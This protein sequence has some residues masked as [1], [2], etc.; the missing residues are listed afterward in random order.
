VAHPEPHLSYTLIETCAGSAA[1]TWHLLGSTR[2]IVPYQGSKWR[3]RRELAMLIAKLGFT[4]KPSHCHLADIGPWGVVHEVLFDEAK[5]AK[6]IAYLE[7]LAEAKDQ[8]ALYQGMLR[9]P[10]PSVQAE[11]VLYVAEFLYLQRLAFSGKAVGAKEGKWTSPG[12]NKTSAYGKAATEVFGEIKPQ[13]PS[14]IRVLGALSPTGTCT[15]TQS[16]TLPEVEGPT[17]A[18]IDPPYLGT[19]KYPD[20]HMGRD[21]VVYLAL[22]LQARGATVLVSEAEPIPELVAQ[23]WPTLQLGVKKGA[24]PFQTTKDTPR[25]EWVTYRR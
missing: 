9:R 16:E 17:L 22:R 12:F 11:P 20:G 3:Y 13:V 10:R 15:S 1:L 2:A 14:M 25:Q 19:T 24:S 8:R 6:V 7:V 23:G 21:E 5:R 4:G 18:F